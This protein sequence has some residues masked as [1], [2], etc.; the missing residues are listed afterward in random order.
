MPTV[1]FPVA[2]AVPMQATSRPTRQPP[3]PV[4][5]RRL[6]ELCGECASG[7][8]GEQVLMMPLWAEA[9]VRVVDGGTA[10]EHGEARPRWPTS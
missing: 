6:P 8:G 4:L 1:S 10:E 9:E 5:N 2:V 7:S 3:W